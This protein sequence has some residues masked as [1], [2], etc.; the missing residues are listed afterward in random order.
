MLKRKGANSTLPLRIHLNLNVLSTNSSVLGDELILK[1]AW[2]V[3][4]QMTIIQGN[5]RE[6]S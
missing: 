3:N 6:E 5:S 1:L 4:Q 2:K